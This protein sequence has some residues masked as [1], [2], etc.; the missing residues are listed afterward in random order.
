MYWAY[1]RLES[2][3]RGYGVVSSSKVTRGWNRIGE[4]AKT[5]N[6]RTEQQQQERNTRNDQ[7]E[8]ISHWICTFL[9]HKRSIARVVQESTKIGPRPDSYMYIQFYLFIFSVSDILSVQNC[10]LKNMKIWTL[11]NKTG[12]IYLEFSTL[13]CKSIGPSSS[14]TLKHSTPVQRNVPLTYDEIN[15][16]VGVVVL[17]KLE[18]GWH[19]PSPSWTLRGWTTLLTTRKR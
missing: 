4:L 9:T 11:K 10:V 3:C 19:G 15:V 1:L 8:I 17:F 5:R 13:V 16:S 2:V 7:E 14:K 18:G 6:H 12:R